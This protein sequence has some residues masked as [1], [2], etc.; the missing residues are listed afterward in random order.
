MER[1][2]LIPSVD[3]NDLEPK[4]P[5]ELEKEQEVAIAAQKL[6]LEQE[7]ERKPA[8]K[9]RG[10][11][12]K[13]LLAILIVGGIIGLG[14]L[15]P[16]KLVPSATSLVS[17]VFHTSSTS[18]TSTAAFENASS[19]LPVFSVDKMSIQSAQAAKI[20]WTGPIRQDGHYA[21]QFPCAD[22]VAII[23]IAADGTKYS[24]PC[25]T[26]FNFMSIDNTL[27]LGIQSRFARLTEVPISFSFIDNKGVATNYGPTNITVVNNSPQTA[28]A[29]STSN[30]ANGGTIIA[31]NNNTSAAPSSNS[32]SQTQTGTVTGGT[33]HPFFES[34]NPQ[35]GNTN[36]GTTNTSPAWTSNTGAVSG[37]GTVS[38]GSIANSS[39][40]AVNNAAQNPSLSPAP[41]YY[42]KADL[43][44]QIISTGI[45]DK[46]T[47][48]FIPRTSFAAG[49][50][51]AV[52]FEIIN[53]GNNYSGHWNFIAGMTRT[54]D[55]NA[56]YR[57]DSQIS[58][59]G[60]QSTLFTIAFDNP[61]LGNQKL[62]FLIDP[63]GLINDANRNNNE[64]IT[65]IFVNN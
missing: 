18:S 3:T 37:G 43:K 58:L 2:K 16:I 24:V 54:N 47:G 1:N 31:N 39:A 56:I 44:V 64:V 32:G 57:S 9:E 53:I 10:L 19:T 55:A 7:E 61:S 17:S 62:D 28:S 12:V 49:D 41:R 5:W 30:S 59:N 60:G 50:R 45:L 51:I 8:A 38:S 63:S 6:R 25:N 42:G 20:S 11:F 46:V 33:G 35:A 52:K 15:L 21:L 34:A 27:T 36:T 22:G 14:I 29:T 48:V 4:T 26:P 13:A 65:P 40:G 23:L